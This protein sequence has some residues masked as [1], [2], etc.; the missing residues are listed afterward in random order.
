M[1]W[2]KDKHTDQLWQRIDA[3]VNLILE[4]DRYM[5][6]KRS[7]ELSTLVKNKFK[8]STRMAER[9]I[10]EA[11]AEIKQIGKSK[12]VKAFDKAIRDRELLFAKA[13][14]ANN[15]KLAL[16]IVIDRDK[17]Y[18]LYVEKVKHSGEV[19]QKITFVEN[20]DE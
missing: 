8:V 2:V 7:K 5:Q 19:K 13:K 1:A 11:R 15:I 6:P 17:I 10:K 14:I 9:Y 20:L 4:N 12:S 3:V 18:G 16:D